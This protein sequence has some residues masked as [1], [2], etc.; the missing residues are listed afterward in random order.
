MVRSNSKSFD[1]AGTSLLHR[2]GRSIHDEVDISGYQILHRRTPAAIGHEPKASTGDLPKEVACDMPHTTDTGMPLACLVWICLQPG[3]ELLQIL[4]G[5]GFLRSD[6]Q[7][8]LAE[9]RDRFE[10]VSQIELKRIEGAIC[11]E[12]V[13]IADGE[14]ITV[15][16]SACDAAGADAPIGT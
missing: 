8:S 11:D 2:I 16:G 13:P 10:I 9:Q 3:D 1:A 12:V 6:Q 14:G 5:H 15:G 7:R 4:C